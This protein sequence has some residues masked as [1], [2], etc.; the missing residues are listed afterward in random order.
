MSHAYYSSTLLW[1]PFSRESLYIE[2]KQFNWDITIPGRMMVAQSDFNAITSRFGQLLDKV[3]GIVVWAA[4]TARYTAFSIPQGVIREES[5][6]V[7]RAPS[8]I[9]AW[10]TKVVTSYKRYRVVLLPGSKVWSTTWTS[11]DPTAILRLCN[12]CCKGPNVLFRGAMGDAKTGDVWFI[13]GTHTRVWRPQVECESGPI[14]V[15]P[16]STTHPAVLSST[17][18]KGNWVTCTTTS[19]GPSTGSPGE[20]CYVPS[21]GTC[22][23][24][25]RQVQ[26]YNTSPSSCASTCIQI[27]GEI[28]QDFILAFMS[29]FHFK[30]E[31]L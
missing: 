6:K 8:P 13:D 29:T 9:S 5:S 16:G 12:S 27:V 7:Y 28:I 20:A 14:L 19:A 11:G 3:W 23:T 24:R 10:L 4:G 15:A 26:K 25:I 18:L 1:V 31:L 21:R 2:F 22:G 17:N 30:S